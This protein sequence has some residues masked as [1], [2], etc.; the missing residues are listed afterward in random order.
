MV[1]YDKDAIVM[2][3]ITKWLRDN[4]KDNDEFLD[5]LRSYAKENNVPVAEPETASFLSVMCKIINPK[6]VL[7]IGTAI[8]YSSIIMAKAAPDAKILTLEYDEETARIAKDN[9]NKAGY[10]DRINVSVAD[11]KDYLSYLYEDETMDLIFLDGPKAHYIYMLDDCVRLLKKGGVLIS[12]NVLYKGMVADDE[13]IISRKIT[14]VERL[15]DYIDAL[16]N[17]RELQTTLLPLGDGVTV[18]VKC[19]KR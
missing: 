11:A 10:T 6:S 14:I 1:E 17:H 8:G 12:D 13:H 18:S 9:I 16:I 19:D 2:P 3:Y 15:R 7:E 5:T 4:A